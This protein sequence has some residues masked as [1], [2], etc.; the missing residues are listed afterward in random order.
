VSSSRLP[1]ARAVVR[2]QI[3]E[4]AST[5]IM[6]SSAPKMIILDEAD[7]MTSAA[8]AA[9][10]RVIEK[11]TRNARFCLI[12]NYASKIIP[13]LQSRCTRFRFAPLGREQ[14]LERV[15][16]VADTEQV[17]YVES[18][19]EACVRLADGDMRRVINVLQSTHMSSNLVD[20]ASVYKCTG[21]PL[22]QDIEFILRSLLEEDFSAGVQSIWELMSEKGLALQDILKDLRDHII[23]LDVKDRMAHAM[24]VA[25]LCDLEHRLSLGTN[26]KMQ[27]AGMVGVFQVSRSALLT[28][29]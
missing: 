20:E 24:L 18:G 22:P 10:R 6:F 13:A 4:F 27:L 1:S 26:D 23:Y 7:N 21:S 14:C 2:D 25:S 11:Y 29:K 9:L 19:L 17:K 8:Q 5:R 15:R 28:S 16:V 3:K 12:C